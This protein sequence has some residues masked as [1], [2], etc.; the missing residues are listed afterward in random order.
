MR[1][2]LLI[3]LLMASQLLLSAKAVFVK[4]TF[5]QHGTQPCE[6]CHRAPPDIDACG[7]GCMHMQDDGGTDAD[8][9]L[10][11]IINAFRGYSFTGIV[12][13]EELAIQPKKNHNITWFNVMENQMAAVCTKGTKHCSAPC[14]PVPPKG[15]GPWLAT[16]PP[17]NNLHREYIQ[18][19][20]GVFVQHPCTDPQREQIL[21]YM[22]SGQDNLRGMEVYNSWVDQAWEALVPL[23]EG[24]IDPIYPLMYKSMSMH[25]WD[26]V[27]RALKRPVYG[28]ADDDGFVYMGDCDEPVYDHEKRD[29]Q[30][31]GPAWFRFGMGWSMVDVPDVKFTAA[32]ITH[33]V[34]QGRFYGSTGIYLEYDISGDILLINASESVIFGAT[35]GAGDRNSTEPLQ[36]FNLTLCSVARGPG[37]GSNTPVEVVTNIG[38][39]ATTAP[40]PPSRELHI[41][42]RKLPVSAPFFFVRV[43]AFVRTR[44]PIVT[45]P[46]SHLKPSDPWKFEIG[47]EPRPGDFAEGRLVRIAGGEARRPFVVQSL[48][49]KTVRFVRYFSDGDGDITPDKTNVT[50]IVA[51]RD[52]LV[53]ERWAWLQ[54]VFRT[55]IPESGVLV[56]PFL[57]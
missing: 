25:Y 53:V 57:N 48:K 42:L 3:G 44:Y 38:C 16:I 18:G 26:T 12:G 7:P 17:V 39:P 56:D 49:N 6:K 21:S 30:T 35:G 43:Q 52:E 9:L 28:L 5:H 54:P 20:P 27:L 4:G 24:D 13:N 23:D 37:F 40:P 15:S 11:A 29:V 31:D 32:D 33:S 14:D 1:T 34:D 51:G 50:G 8:V 22:V 19:V 47:V 41:D 46:P 36:G 2:L 45:T 10:K 55:L